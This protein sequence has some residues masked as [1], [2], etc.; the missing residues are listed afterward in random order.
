MQRFFLNLLLL[1]LVPALLL[2]CSTGPSK[3]GN[4]SQNAPNDLV[5][6]ATVLVGNELEYQ[7]RRRGGV[8]WPV[9][10]RPSRSI[11]MPDGALRSDVG[12]TLGVD[13][14]PG[15]SRQLYQA[16]LNTLW[17]TLGD[18]G[19]QSPVPGDLRGNPALL[20][21]MSQEIIQ[22]LTIQA[23]GRT[24]TL[25]RSFTPEREK[26]GSLPSNGKAAGEDPRMRAF[27]RRLLA[28]AW[29]SDLPP[30]TG[31][32]VPERYD[33]GPDPWERYRPEAAVGGETDS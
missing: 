33:F 16:Q 24:W 19:F 6:D 22:I 30:E 3:T 25:V 32:V 18:L 8:G 12:R 21:P 29:A 4:D 7:M 5:I 15:I 20:E 1:S 14:R 11:V 31:F 9:H 2:G 28:L 26:D 23:R 17:T 27:L 13:D 10:L